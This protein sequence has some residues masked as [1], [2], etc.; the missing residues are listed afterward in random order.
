[1]LWAVDNEGRAL[2]SAFEFDDFWQIDIEYRA[3]QL[4][5]IKPL[6]SETHGGFR[7]R[8]EE[9]AVSWLEFISRAVT[10]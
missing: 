8:S 3:L 4:V 5:G 7:V 6:A 9:Q 1:M 2:V 10:R